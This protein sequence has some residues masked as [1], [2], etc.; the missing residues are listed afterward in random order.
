ML[1]LFFILINGPFEKSEKKKFKWKLTSLRKFTHRILVATS[2]S[3]SARSFLAL[4]D[5]YMIG[6]EAAAADADS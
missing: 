5:Q 4:C 6:I 3:R 1:C 2:C